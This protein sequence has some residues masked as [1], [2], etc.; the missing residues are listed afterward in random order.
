MVSQGMRNSKVSNISSNSTPSNTA[1][2]VPLN[3]LWEHLAAV[4]PRLPNVS[5]SCKMRLLLRWPLG[6][7]KL[8]EFDLND[9]FKRMKVD[10]SGN[11]SMV[12]RSQLYNVT[13]TP[14]ASLWGQSQGNR[15]SS[16]QPSFSQ[17][18]SDVESSS[19]VN[20]PNLPSN[21][22]A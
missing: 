12:F 8:G 1:N 10:E 20:Y 5:L 4:K 6:M 3:Q 14:D 7:M 9:A 21:F 13:L 19:S 11:I 18:K 17:A 16:A 22:D 15:G 2:K